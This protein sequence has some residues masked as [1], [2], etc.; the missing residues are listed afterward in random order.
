MQELK[1]YKIWALWNPFFLETNDPSIKSEYTRK[2]KEKITK[3][4]SDLIL[5]KIY[6]RI[7]ASV[8]IAKTKN[9]GRV[10]QR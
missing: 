4:I 1:L 8:F 3:D 7:N 5:A 6:L 10:R 9:H 2:S